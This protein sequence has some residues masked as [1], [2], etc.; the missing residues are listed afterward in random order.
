MRRL[1]VKLVVLA[2]PLL[3]TA[4]QAR[5]E[6]VLFACSESCPLALF[7]ALELE[8]RGHGAFLVSRLS[9]AG[10]T[11]EA[12]ESDAQRMAA[13]TPAAAVLWIERDAP[14]RVRV[15]SPK[16][17]GVHEAPLA[18]APEEIEPRLF[19][20]IAGNV[21]LQALA[22]PDHEENAAAE[23]AP[24]ESAPVSPPAPPVPSFATSPAPAKRPAHMK[25]FFLRVGPALGVAFVKRGLSAD[26]APPSAYVQEAYANQIAMNSAEAGRESLAA[27][28]YDC[29]W[30]A[31]STGGMIATNCRVTVK[32][33]GYVFVP[34]V[35][36]QAGWYIT[37]RFALAAFVRIT[38][39]AGHG[40]LRHAVIGA[41]AEYALIAPRPSGFW[42]NLG[43]GMGGGRIQVQ[44]PS[45]SR[46][47]KL[48]FVTSGLG[49]A[50]ALVALGYRFLPNIGLY[51]TP[52][53]RLFFPDKLWVF[54]PTV[55]VEA[56]L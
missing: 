35:D 25:R 37:P 53:V 45:G 17:P 18:S 7:E 26:R 56:R 28:G 4:T 43:I 41:Q 48:P 20:A 27:R 44:P 33:N 13:L 54:E 51:T 47:S 5:A 6:T 16:Q 50:H 21:V 38:P 42:T 3:A 39:K 30:N 11:V 52:S 36:L 10:Y 2:F 14:M 23:V 49:E 40:L 19:A 46:L 22:A 12:H 24:K 1:A 34:G 55:G 31:K 29:D 9:P 15:L 8:L 32:A